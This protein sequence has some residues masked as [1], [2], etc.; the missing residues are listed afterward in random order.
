M[1]LAQVSNGVY[2]LDSTIFNIVKIDNVWA[3]IDL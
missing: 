3:Q 2:L 1:M